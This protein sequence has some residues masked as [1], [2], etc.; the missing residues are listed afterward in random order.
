MP[1]ELKAFDFLMR[2]RSEEPD[3][4]LLVVTITEEDLQTYKWPL[5]DAVM[6]QLLAKLLALQPNVIG[7]DNYRDIPVKEGHDALNTLLQ[8]SER[9][10]PVCK[11]SDSDSPGVPPP[12]GVPNDRLGFSD[13]VI[14]SDSVVRRRTFIPRT[15]QKLSLCRLFIPKL[16]TGT[17]LSGTIWHPTSTQLA[18]AALF[19]QDYLQTP[20][21]QRRW[22]PKYRLRR[23][24]NPNQLPQ[25]SIFRQA[26]YLNRRPQR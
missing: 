17:K 10:I 14:D 11:V 3:S 5:S 8:K 24:P 4:R 16:P 9:I 20:Q 25:S 7:L 1:M 19:W 15:T 21:T 12:P 18:T 2:Q 22:L 6:H 23:I 13:T 26:S